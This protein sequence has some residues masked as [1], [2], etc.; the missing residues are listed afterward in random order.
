MARTNRKKF[1][2]QED[3]FKMTKSEAKHARKT[4]R[5]N[6]NWLL[7]DEDDDW[8]FYNFNDEE[9]DLDNLSDILIRKV[10]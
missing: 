2:D 7:E 8:E 5:Q 3:N 4:A 6:K 1:R 10:V 9:K